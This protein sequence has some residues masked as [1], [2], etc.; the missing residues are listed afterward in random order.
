M[1]NKDGK[2]AEWEI[3]TVRS[4]FHYFISSRECCRGESEHQHWDFP[5]V[6]ELR[7]QWL[8]KGKGRRRAGDV[9]IPW[10][11]IVMESIWSALD[12]YQKRDGVFALKG[13][14]INK[15]VRQGGRGCGC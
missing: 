8:H 1:K 9:Y 14:S 13:I 2:R 3:H 15:H 12:P 10:I 4:A 11:S 6:D 5:A 7:Q